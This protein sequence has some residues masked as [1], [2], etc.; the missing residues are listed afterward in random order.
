MPSPVNRP[1]NQDPMMR[2]IFWGKCDS[3]CN[4]D[5]HSHFQ[6]T[7]P[8]WVFSNFVPRPE[9]IESYF[10]M[11]RYTKKQKYRDWAWEA[12]QVTFRQNDQTQLLLLRLSR[13][14][15]KRHGAIQ[16]WK[17][18]TKTRPRKMTCNSRSSL[19]KHSSKLCLSW[20]FFRSS[21]SKLW[22]VP[23]R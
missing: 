2:T 14:T 19:P 7:N 5:R 3:T 23:S 1:L 10:Y 17:M 4:A 21:I 12:V 22:T 20:C 11:W 9:V 8:T 6:L 18:L 16:A 13:S 15:A